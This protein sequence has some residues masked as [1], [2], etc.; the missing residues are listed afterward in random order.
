MI[1]FGIYKKLGHRGDLLTFYYMYLLH[2]VQALGIIETG[3]HLLYSVFI[4]HKR[5]IMNHAI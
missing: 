3:C 4:D 5:F 1:L 2:A